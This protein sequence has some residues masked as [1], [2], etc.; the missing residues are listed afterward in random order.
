[1]L[2]L[3]TSFGDPASDLESILASFR[4]LDVHAVALHRPARSDE[5]RGLARFAR[6][7]KFVAVF[8]DA[9][10]ADVGRSAIVVVD[11]GPAAEDRERSLEELCRK[12]H[13]LKD[14]RVALRTPP[15]PDHHPSSD[16]IALVAEALGFVGYWHDAHRDGAAHRETAARYLEGAHGHP[17]EIADLSGLRDALPRAAPFV[18]ACPSGTERDELD[19]A[20]RCA[21]G[22]FTG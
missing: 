13:G 1:M 15:S 7:L 5:A 16:E 17:L 3:S 14:Y 11:G 18:V 10:G 21:R 8:G 6:H 22:V 9:P 4:G 2:A 19:E 12:L 20:L